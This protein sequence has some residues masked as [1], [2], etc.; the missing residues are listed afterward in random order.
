MPVS[1]VISRLVSPH[2]PSRNLIAGLELVVAR[3]QDLQLAGGG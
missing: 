3:G 1:L 2:S